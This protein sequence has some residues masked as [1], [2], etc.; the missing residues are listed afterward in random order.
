M[1]C[2]YSGSLFLLLPQHFYSLFQFLLSCGLLS[3]YFNSFTHHSKFSPSSFKSIVQIPTGKKSLLKHLFMIIYL[4]LT[5]K[6]RTQSNSLLCF[7][8]CPHPFISLLY[9][10]FT[11]VKCNFFSVF[12]QNMAILTSLLFPSVSPPTQAVPHLLCF[13]FWVV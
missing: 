8:D 12:N 6:N 5:K 9:N 4:N 1:M 2:R 13:N 3:P 7:Q 10:F 11:S